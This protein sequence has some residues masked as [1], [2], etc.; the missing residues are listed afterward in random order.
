[1]SDS[2]MKRLL[3]AVW[4][5]LILL[6]VSCCSRNQD[7]L[8]DHVAR[9]EEPPQRI[10]SRFSVDAPLL[11]NGYMGVAMSGSPERLAFYLNRNDFWR[12]VSAHDESFPAIAGRLELAV[13]ALEGA[14]YEVEQHLW[15]ATTLGRFSKDG[16]SASLEAYVAATEDIL[17]LRITNEGGE[18]LSGRA[19]LLLPDPSPFPEKREEGVTPEGIQFIY[20]GFADSVEIP[21]ASASALLVPGSADGSFSLAPGESLV[22]ACAT[23]GSIKADDCL[24]AASRLA[25]ACDKRHLSEA[26]KAH[27][28]WW[29]SYWNKSWV[30]IPD[31]LIEKQYYLSLYGMASCS[32]DPDFPPSLFGNWITGEIPAW[33]GDYHLNYNH[34]A[35]YYGLYSS[36]RLEQA[37]PYYGPLLAAIPRGQFYS[38]SVCGIPDGILLPVGIGPL[39]IETTRWSA[40]LEKAHPAWKDSGNI[41][42]GGMFWGQK[43]N[44]AYA[45]CN[46]AMQ[47]YRTLD[48]DFTEK[49]YPFVK[50]VATFWEKYLVLEGDRYV[51]LNDAIHEG[52]LGTKNP[53]CSLGLVRLVM[54]TA[55]D[56]SELLGVDFGRCEAWKDCHDRL[57]GY[58]LQERGGK[59]VFRYTEEGVAWWNDNTLGIQHIYPAGQIGLSSNPGLLETAR[60]TIE[61]MNRWMDFNG[62][63]SLYP[64]AVR[65]GYPA[66]SILTHLHAYALHTYPNG[67]QRDNPHGPE[68][69]ST[70]PATVNEML[71]M[72]HQGIVRLFPV[73]PRS[74][75]AAFHQLRVEGAFL[76]SAALKDGE[77]GNVTLLSER[78]TLLSMQNPWPGREVEITGPGGRKQIVGGE[79]LKVETTPGSTYRFRAK[80]PD[81]RRTLGQ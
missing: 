19:R 60:N 1:M 38:G 34:M 22:M 54:E 67:F 80:N 8:P 2:I 58:P 32:R 46:L 81:R 77:I 17:V 25:A 12:L 36:N 31:P 61:E 65:V 78:G 55:C 15:D 42:C 45:V 56:M 69:W 30:R 52:T 27:E 41:E 28:R 64:A 76:V 75:D 6:I 3:L 48:R 51:I 23:A 72:G 10:P 35:P 71:C 7:F 21:A 13:P 57:A 53:I 24:Q 44:S 68:N 74:L 29:A 26:R 11:G 63:N 4:T 66:D 5:V 33:M 70:V 49:V 43:S 37:D 47:F 20:R 59:T 73:W 50:G 14:S 9:F 62:T 40:S 18:S 79:I 39:G 16:V